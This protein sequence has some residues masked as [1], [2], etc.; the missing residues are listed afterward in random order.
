MSH[1][2]PKDKL[3]ISLDSTKPDLSHIE[4]SL[5]K[6]LTESINQ[7]GLTQKTLHQIRINNVYLAD[8]TD[9]IFDDSIFENDE[10]D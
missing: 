5:D 7:V 9:N 1:I 4:Q 8:V 3:L 2:V 10:I 6:Q